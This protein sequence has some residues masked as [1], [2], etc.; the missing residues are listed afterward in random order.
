MTREQIKPG[1]MVCVPPN[2]NRDALV[3]TDCS[4]IVIGLVGIVQ[5]D[6]GTESSEVAL[7]QFPFIKQNWYTPL[8]ELRTINEEAV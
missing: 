8:S 7:V 1:K 4:D 2:A 3:V 5:P 6:D